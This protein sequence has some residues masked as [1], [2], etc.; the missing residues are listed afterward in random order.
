MCRELFPTL[1]PILL[2]HRF[3]KHRLWADSYR[4]E[5]LELLVF[6]SNTSKFRAWSRRGHCHLEGEI[7]FS[8]SWLSCAEVFALHLGSGGDE[9]GARWGPQGEG[10]RRRGM[11]RRGQVAGQRDLIQSPN[12]PPTGWTTLQWISA[13]G[14]LGRTQGSSTSPA[15][16][17]FYRRG[18]R[19]R[20]FLPHH[21]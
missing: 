4:K 11:E 3:L 6:S 15:C 7:Q 19:C 8:A 1:L 13:P 17:S 20:C 21:K 12:L 18:I 14:P 2:Q 16:P 10:G 9:A 5:Q